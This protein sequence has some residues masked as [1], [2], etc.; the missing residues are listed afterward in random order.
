MQEPI[1]QSL[2]PI[3]KLPFL[4][5]FCNKHPKPILFECVR[6]RK[7]QKDNKKQPKCRR[8]QSGSA[9]GVVTVA[10]YSHSRLVWPPESLIGS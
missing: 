7:T 4:F 5:N 8:N 6:H 1:H 9:I 3:Q 10:M 2:H